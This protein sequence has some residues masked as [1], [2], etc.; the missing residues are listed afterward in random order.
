[1]NNQMPYPY[2]SNM[3]GGMPGNMP[4][5]Y[6]MQHPGCHCSGE[7]KGLEN[8]INKLERSVKRLEDAM[9]HMQNASPYNSSY[10]STNYQMM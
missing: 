5:P 3:S 1:M 4:G 6:T 2:P 7:L 9:M 10:D 8:R